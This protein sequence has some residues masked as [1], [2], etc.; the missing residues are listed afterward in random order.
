[1]KYAGTPLAGL[2]SGTNGGVAVKRCVWACLLVIS[3][4]ETARAGTPATL[5]RWQERGSP[6]TNRG[7]GQPM[8]RLEA[9]TSWDKSAVRDASRYLVRIHVPGGADFTH[10]LAAREVPPSQSVSVLIPADAIRNLRPELVN[11]SV[12]IVDAATG[13]SVS[14]ALEATIEDFANPG[15]GENEE[16]RGPFGWGEPLDFGTSGAAELPNAAP[17]GLRF[18]R[19]KP[20]DGKPGFTISIAEVSASQAKNA[21][22]DY[23]PRAGRSDDFRLDAADQPAVALSPAKAKTLLE[24]LGKLDTKSASYRLPTE[25]EW[26]LAAKAGKTSAFWWGEEASHFSGANLLGPEPALAADTT[27]SVLPSKSE[28][29]FEANPWGLF[30]TFGNVAEWGTTPDGAFVRMGGSFRTEPVSPLPADPVADADSTG[31]DAFVGVRPIL[32]LSRESGAVLIKQALGTEKFWDGV[33]VSYDPDRATAILSGNVGLSAHRKLA[34]RRLHELWFLS[35]VENNIV[36]PEVANGFLARL[37]SR[38]VAR[39]RKTPLGKTIDELTIPVRWAAELPVE[40]SRWY[41]N[42]FSKDGRVFSHPIVDGRPDP[43]TPLAVSVDRGVIGIKDDGVRVG[44]SLGAPASS[45]QD[46]NIVSN[47]ILLK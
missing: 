44:L 27:A 15:P 7:P 45:P 37:E 35:A 43:R 20:I 33:K 40:G 28:L 14:N 2:R 26:Q 32:D 22:K 13:N 25:A 19:V 41:V 39:K 10:P 9:V 21:W 18:A 23:D 4:V 46:P 1:M 42:V 17:S 5:H 12:D 6:V 16:D 3:L 29:D 24:A 36:G 30:H 8:I 38:I 47:L 31:A 11:V 34:D